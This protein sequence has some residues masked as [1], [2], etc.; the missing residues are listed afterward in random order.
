MKIIP[1][2]DNTMPDPSIYPSRSLFRDEQ[3]FYYCFRCAIIAALQNTVITLEKEDRL[4][5]CTKCGLPI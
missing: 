4:K 2:V 1:S 5:N 3:G